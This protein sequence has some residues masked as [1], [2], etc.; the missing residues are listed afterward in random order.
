M[1]D[2]EMWKSAS[3]LEQDDV[4]IYLRAMVADLHSRRC[5]LPLI[6]VNKFCIVSLRMQ[7]VLCLFLFVFFFVPQ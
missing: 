2:G 3:L 5:I 7:T 1:D 4:L 6:K